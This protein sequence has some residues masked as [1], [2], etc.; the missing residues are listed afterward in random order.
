MVDLHIR[1]R[2]SVVILFHETIVAI[3]LEF[4]CHAACPSKPATYSSSQLGSFCVYDIALPLSLHDLYSF[5]SRT[6]RWLGQSVLQSVII[7]YVCFDIL[8]LL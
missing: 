2:I 8:L 1:I 7:L 4:T 6:K 3:T 5:E